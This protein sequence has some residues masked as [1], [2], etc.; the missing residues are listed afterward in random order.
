MSHIYDALQRS[1]AERAGADVP[2][3]AAIEL[4]ER[5][6]RQAASRWKPESAQELAVAPEL[7][8][9]NLALGA[10]DLLPDKSATELSAAVE[11]LQA[12]EKRRILAQFNTLKVSLPLHSRLVC[13]TQPDSP[14]TEAFRLLGVRLRHLREGRS[15]K[16]ILVTSTVPQEGKSTIT[17]NLACTLA[18]GARRNILLLEG[19]VRRPSLSQLFGLGPLPGLCDFLQKKCSLTSAIYRLEEPGFWILPAGSLDANPPEI[20]QSPKLTALMDQLASWFDRVLIDSPPVLPLADTS[21]WTRVAEGIVLVARQ[22]T[23]ERR[24]L[25]RGL[26]A[27]DPQKLLGVIMNSSTNSS[28]HEYYYY[29]RSSDSTRPGGHS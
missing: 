25:R 7:S 2:A 3:T 10:Q 28:D 18:T 11:P 23:T 6:E 27:L 14:A 5:A 20:L 26:E 17:A 12:E 4:L 21:L 16:K 29:S 9:G 13:L 19:D 1:E 22:G 15:F 8:N 24:Q